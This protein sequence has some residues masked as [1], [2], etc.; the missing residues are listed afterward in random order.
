MVTKAGEIELDTVIRGAL[1]GNEIAEFTYTATNIC[2]L[3]IFED[4]ADSVKVSVFD[5]NNN[6]V[7]FDFGA[8]GY[9]L[10]AGDYTFKVSVIGA[11]FDKSS[12]DDNKFSIK[13]T[14]A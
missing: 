5:A 9:K 12:A 4:P 11:D 10:E 1:Y 3:K 8:N 7:D 13:A 14:L 6:K 2:T